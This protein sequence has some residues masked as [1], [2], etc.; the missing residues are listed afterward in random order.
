M[1]LKYSEGK[2][3]KIVDEQ[4]L[5]QANIVRRDKANSQSHAKKE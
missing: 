4:L 2:E 3:E 1:H 5:Y